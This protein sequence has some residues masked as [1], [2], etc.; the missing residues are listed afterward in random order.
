M[1]VLGG[2]LT[3]C[4]GCSS[5]SRNTGGTAGVV[6]SGVVSMV[7]SM[8]KRSRSHQNDR[9]NY[10]FQ[11]SEAQHLSLTKLNCG[12]C[13]LKMLPLKNF[14]ILVSMSVLCVFWSDHQ[15][16]PSFTFFHFS[17]SVSRNKTS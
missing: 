5:E 10:P 6:T 7:R 4:G 11:K 15:R 16:S 17:Q 3:K 2:D 14:E 1:L 12:T 8:E 13:V 9:A